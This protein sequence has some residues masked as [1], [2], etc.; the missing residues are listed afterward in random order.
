MD[1]ILHIDFE[2]SSQVDI[3][4]VGVHRYVADPTTEVICCAYAFDDE[5]VQAILYDVQPNRVIKHIERGGLVYAHNATMEREVIK[6]FWGLEPNMRCTSAVACYHALPPSLD[7]VAKFLG[8][9]VRKDAEG[10]EVLKKY[11]KT[12]PSEIPNSDLGSILDY[13]VKDVEVERAIHHRLGDLP[14]RE[15]KLWQL[16]QEMNDRGVRIDKE[17]GEIV[18]DEVAKATVPLMDEITELSG[19]AVTKPTQNQRIVK[20]MAEQGYEIPNLR[21]ETV[22]DIRSNDLPAHVDRMMWIRQEGGGTSIGKFKKGLAMLTR[23]HRV[24]GNLR[25]HG[26]TTGRWAGSGLQLHNLPRGNVNDT[27]L[28]AEKFLERDIDAVI[29][30]AGNVF[31]GAKS[32]V[33]PFMTASRGCKLVVADYSSIEA[34]VLAWYAGQND[35]VKEFEEGADIY[36]SFASSIFGKNITKADKTERMVG[37]VGILGLGYGMGAKKFKGTL[38]DWCGLEVDLMFAQKVVD[39]YRGRYQHIKNLWWNLNSGAIEAMTEGESSCGRWYRGVGN[40]QFTLPSGRI[41]FYQRPRIVVGKFGNDALQYI[42]PKD[43]QLVRSD[44]YGGKLCEN[45]V[46]AIARDLMADALL[47]ADEAGIRLLLTVHD[48]II[49]EAPAEEAGLALERLEAIMTA[50]IQWASGVPLAV[51]GFTNFRFKK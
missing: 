25:Y 26:A 17:L 16:D 11:Y 28:L 9:P 41:L 39:T 7:A 51:E 18:I 6:K 48:E 50:P 43:G 29:E 23:G 15:L 37:K 30:L 10:S 46:Q 35:L 20:W 31:D 49:A 32:A 13:C 38:K 33:R 47:R 2:T 14:A 8:L 34:R 1:S 40:L 44:T 42:R 5:P 36:C 3:K 22:A 19:G 21:K 12:R 4:D 45:I 24:R 27:D